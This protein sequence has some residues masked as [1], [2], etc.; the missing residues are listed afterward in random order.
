MREADARAVPG[1][2]TPS[3]LIF[4]SP[5]AVRR[6]WTYPHDWRTVADADL[7]ALLD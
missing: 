5:A 3:C 7:L 2:P 1:A 6:L 4:D